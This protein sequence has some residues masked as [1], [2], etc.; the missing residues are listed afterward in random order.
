MRTKTKIIQIFFL[1]AIS[2]MAFSQVGINA[3]GALPAPSAMLDISSTNKGVLLPRMTTSSRQA[4]VSPAQGLTVFDTDT[5]TFW[6]FNGTIWQNN[7]PDCNN[8]GYGGWGDC[9]TNNVIGDY[10]PVSADDVQPGDDFGRG[11]DISGNYAI[12]GCWRDDDTIGVDQGSAYVYKLN[13]NTGKWEFLQ[14]LFNHDGAPSDFFGGYVA[15]YGDYAMVGAH[16]DDDLGGTDQGSV[17]F[18]KRNASTGLFEFQQKVFN[19]TPATQ[20][21]FG[22]SLDMYGDYAVIGAINDQNETGIKVGSATVFKRNAATDTWQFQ[23]KLLNVNPNLGDL[24]GAA[25][26]IFQNYIIVGA[27][28]DD[29]AVGPDQGSALIFKRNTVTDVWEVQS[30]IFNNEAMIGDLF[31]ISV[32]INNNYAIVGAYKDDD[33]GAV[34]QGSASIYKF[35]AATQQWDFQQK[36]LNTN[37]A[38]LDNYGITTSISDEYAFVGSNLV[39]GIAGVDQGSATLYKRVGNLWQKAQF[40]TDPAGMAGDLFGARIRHD[41]ATNRFIINA[42]HLYG[43]GKVLFGKIN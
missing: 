39:D 33:I 41:P 18:F 13:A 2:N 15:I 29:D 14:K 1:L 16:D 27:Y 43:I 37:A 31:G 26:S 40:I 38:T 4:I 36:L 6:Y 34:D 24:F 28:K 25:V 21:F 42:F 35:N 5:K 19:N 32:A 20:D 30:Q 8:L 11:V 7:K 22:L 3:T 12:V 23:Q 9:A 10:F 17:C